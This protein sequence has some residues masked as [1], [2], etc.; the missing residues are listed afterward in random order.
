MFKEV[1]NDIVGIKNTDSIPEVLD[2]LLPY[3]NDFKYNLECIDNYIEECRKVYN[4]K[5]ITF[6]KYEGNT[7]QWIINNDIDYIYW[8]IDNNVM[9][10]DIKYM[11]IPK[12]K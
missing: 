4:N 9:N 5:I 2:K 10:L 3:R 1:I 7:L 6:G 8:L 12:K 11:G